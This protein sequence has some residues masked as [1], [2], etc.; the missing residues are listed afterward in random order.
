MYLLSFMVPAV[1]SNAGSSPDALALEVLYTKK[2]HIFV[3]IKVCNLNSKQN[4]TFYQPTFQFQLYFFT[5]TFL[6]EIK[7]T[8]SINMSSETSFLF[9]LASCRLHTTLNF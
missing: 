7:T 1:A 2:T 3:K 4:T 6:I 8:D 5:L 9:V